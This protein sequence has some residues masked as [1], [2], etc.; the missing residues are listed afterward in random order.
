MDSGCSL[1]SQNAGALLAVLGPDGT[2]LWKRKRLL[3]GQCSYY[4][5]V[6]A[7]GT[8]VVAAGVR[9]STQG[10]VERF[11]ADGALLWSRPTELLDQ[12]SP[13]GLH[14]DSGGLRLVD[15]HPR[16]ARVLALTADGSVRF[17][18]IVST[19]TAAPYLMGVI[20]FG[21]GQIWAHADRIERVDAF[22]HASCA[23]SGPCADKTVADCNDG[24]PCTL[25]DC[26]ADHGGC[27]HKTAADG[28][29]CY[30]GATCQAGACK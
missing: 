25:D 29:Y 17:E 14:V 24:D 20:L 10:V 3:G 2:I 4:G 21:K 8:D 19:S 15:P 27:W 9:L 12:G 22:G 1:G 6:A 18:H 5:A 13:R 7:A 26:D 23:A 28:A 16:A 30:P 11:D